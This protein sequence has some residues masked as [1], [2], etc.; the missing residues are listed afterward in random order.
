M[1]TLS[2][3]HVS[4]CGSSIRVEYEGPETA[5]LVTFLYRDIANDPDI[6]PHIT[7]RLR[8]EDGVFRL[9]CGQ[10]VR[11]EGSCPGQAANTLLNETIYHLADKNRDGL[12]FHA[13]AVALNGRC[14]LLP[15]KTGAGKTTLAAWLVKN[16]FVYLTDELV[17]IAPGSR[18]VNALRRPLNVKKGSLPVLETLGV[19]IKAPEIVSS[20]EAALVPHVLL[21]TQD[22]RVTPPLAALIFPHHQP[23]SRFRVEPLTSGQTALALVE[24][25]INA[26]NLP[27]HG[28]PA[29]ARLS[30]EVQAFR[31]S[32]ADFEQIQG[33]MSDLMASNLTSLER[34]PKTRQKTRPDSQLLASLDPK[35]KLR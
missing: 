3:R 12:L 8:S 27:K 24:C 1:N 30:K 16:G 21:G 13:A 4:F 10:D 19:D 22:G 29:I 11:Y 18:V 17:H 23:G 26:R 28:V 15:G 32:Y 35:P 7:F 14:L 34:H 9:E 33:W 2:N 6:P 5:R 25:L 20:S 31:M